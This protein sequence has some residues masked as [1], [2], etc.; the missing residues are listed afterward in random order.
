[1]AHTRRWR[2][3]KAKDKKVTMERVAEA[4]DPGDSYNQPAPE[5]GGVEVPSAAA[6][7]NVLM[8][9]HVVVAGTHKVTLAVTASHAGPNFMMLGITE[10]RLLAKSLI[11][12]AQYA[13]DANKK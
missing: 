1:M 2:P 10:A 6:P 9:G 4:E 8:A 5:P 13:D 3:V 11:E 12:W 7:P